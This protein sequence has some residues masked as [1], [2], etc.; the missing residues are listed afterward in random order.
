M[1]KIGMAPR[2]SAQVDSLSDNRIKIRFYSFEKIK[3]VIKDK[4]YFSAKGQ[5]INNERAICPIFLDNN[6]KI[7]NFEFDTATVA[8][9]TF[10]AVD[11]SNKEK[12]AISVKIS[13]EKV[14][15]TQMEY[16][17]D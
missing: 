9:V 5:C 13:N 16:D 14:D 11:K 8:T 17:E 2:F 12:Y 15:F 6:F 3:L 4:K 7:V 1:E 10:I